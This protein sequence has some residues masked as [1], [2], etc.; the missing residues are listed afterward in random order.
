MTRVI[1]PVRVITT[2]IV[3]SAAIAA[4]VTAARGNWVLVWG[5]IAI[6]AC[7]RLLGDD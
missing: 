7:V 4:G 2:L 3:Y 1:D 6:Y 5:M